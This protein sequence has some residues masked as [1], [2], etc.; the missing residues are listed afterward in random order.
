MCIRDRFSL[1]DDRTGTLLESAASHDT[2]HEPAAV[3][4]DDVAVI[5]Y[6][7][8]TTGRSKGAMLSH[9]NLLANTETLHAYWGWR[10]GDVLI[11][12]L[13]VSYTHLKA[14]G[15]LLNDR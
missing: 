5:L 1:N 11:H 12:A 8:G 14:C 9:A 15:H 13:P 3:R 7:S 2:R 4:A 10:P 6:T